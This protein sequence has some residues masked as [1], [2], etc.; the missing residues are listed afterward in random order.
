MAWMVNQYVLRV[1]KELL[2]QLKTTISETPGQGKRK[3][4]VLMIFKQLSAEKKEKD[5]RD[6]RN[7]TK[8]AF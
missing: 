3:E 6:E 1:G 8:V 4:N 5:D 2:V 7:V